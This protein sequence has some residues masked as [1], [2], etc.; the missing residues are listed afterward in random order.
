MATNLSLDSSDDESPSIAD[1]ATSDLAS[2][3]L[4]LEEK[5]NQLSA[6]LENRK[7]QMFDPMLLR[8]AQGFFAPTKTGRFTESLGNVAGGV[9]EEQAKKQAEDQANLEAQ[10]KLA[11]LKYGM[12]KEDVQRNFME[13]YGEPNATR[14]VPVAN[15]AQ[16]PV[17]PEE[18]ATSPNFETK[19]QEPT[20][21]E[22]KYFD[23]STSIRE[24][25]K[26]GVIPY[27]KYLELMTKEQKKEGKM[28]TSEEAKAN[29]LPTEKGERWNK[30]ASGTFEI[31]SGTTP[32]EPSF[33]QQM[34]EKDVANGFKG[35]WQ[36]WK[37]QE[38]PFQKA[39]IS[40]WNAQDSRKDSGKL[41]AESV[42]ALAD[43]AL[44]G[45]KSV[46]IGLGRGDAGAYNLSAVRKRMVEKMKMS[47]MTGAQI[48][49][50]NAEFN[51]I[52]AAERTASVK[53]ANIELAG[54]EFTNII[55]IAQEASNKVARSKFKPFG[56]AQIMFDENFND[57]DVSSFA[58]ANNGLVN[59]YSRAISPTGIPSVE[60]KRHA[61]Q[62][63]SIAKNQESYNSA[64]N[65]LQREIEAAKKSP[66]QVRSSLSEAI[67]GDKSVSSIS[68]DDEDLINKHLNKRP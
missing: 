56:N 4:M 1:K 26:A 5:L 64:V 58:A 48:A 15:N 35:S 46:F 44:T 55:P 30:T 42:D 34:F 18:G 27:E 52:V 10:F 24:A 22:E 6:S 23:P 57:P 37:S 8:A 53:G 21:T 7:K 25:V 62:I 3:R 61:R 59:T 33:E 67:K 28:L 51:G 12:N 14:R 60:D 49:V 68:K 41:D 50:K 47:G 43:Q 20:F 2:G 63:L 39:E 29:G 11:Q 13:H 38:T 65:T 16:I 45:D 17:P 19:S 66:G 36:Q 9:A 31:V 54:N 32:K 40:R